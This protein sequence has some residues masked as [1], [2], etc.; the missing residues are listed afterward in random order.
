MAKGKQF[1]GL[2][3][4]QWELEHSKLMENKMPLVSDLPEKR[5]IM[6]NIPRKK[7]LA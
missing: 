1:K 5:P 2:G 7:A 4:R 6:S 3:T